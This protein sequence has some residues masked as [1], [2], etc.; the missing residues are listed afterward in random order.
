[1]KKVHILI[2]DYG[3]D[4]E[5]I[6]KIYL[7]EENANKDMRKLNKLLENN[8]HDVKEE[9]EDQFNLFSRPEDVEVREYEVF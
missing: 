2:A 4:G 8:I 7:E 3:Y 6:L 9:L 5:S 1:M